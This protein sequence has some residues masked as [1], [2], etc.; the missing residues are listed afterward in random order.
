MSSSG[1]RNVIF[2]KS[3]VYDTYLALPTLQRWQAC[4]LRHRSEDVI[5]SQPLFMGSVKRLRIYHPF[6]DLYFSMES[7]VE[8]RRMIDFLIISTDFQETAYL[9]RCLQYSKKKKKKN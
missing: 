7:P 9:A 8:Q 4:G 1:K 2:V 6:S 5:R 3:S